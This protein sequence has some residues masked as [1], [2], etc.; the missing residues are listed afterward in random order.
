MGLSRSQNMARILAADTSPEKLIRRALWHS[1]FRYRIQHV[2]NGIKTDLAF[3]KERV[4]LFVDGCFWHGCPEHYVR[5]RS[6]PGFWSKKLRQNVERDRRQTQELENNG[7]QV[8]R[9]WEH[10]VHEALPSVLGRVKSALNQVPS[11]QRADDWRV[12]SVTPLDEN[13]DY[14]R[15]LLVSL[16]QPKMTRKMDQKRHTRKWRASQDA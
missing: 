7:W 10:E 13:G 11:N 8:C 4:A 14:E 16:R 2:V 9:F 1:G 6:N 12:V 3:P 5:P 15:R